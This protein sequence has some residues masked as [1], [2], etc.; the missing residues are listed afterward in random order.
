MGEE[1]QLVE[2]NRR[3]TEIFEQ[4]IKDRISEIWGYGDADVEAEP[5]IRN[6]YVAAS[7]ETEIEMSHIEQV[8]LF[9]SF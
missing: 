9:T 7:D 2:A 3:L 4:K 6:N 5:E 1:Q 8:A